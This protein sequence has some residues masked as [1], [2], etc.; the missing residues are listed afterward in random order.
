[1]EIFVRCNKCGK[2]YEVTMYNAKIYGP[3]VYY[4]CHNC[5]HLIKRNISAFIEKNIMRN[6]IRI[7]DFAAIRLMQQ[8]GRELERKVVYGFD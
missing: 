5:K 8:I 1:M 3:I 7:G 2:S 6:G 4:T